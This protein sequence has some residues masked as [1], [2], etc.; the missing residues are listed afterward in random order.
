MRKQTIKLVYFFSQGKN[1]A[2]SF[3]GQ[4]K[5]LWRHFLFKMTSSFLIL[6][7]FSLHFLSR[8]FNNKMLFGRNLKGSIIVSILTASF[9]D[10]HI[11]P[12]NNVVCI[13]LA[14]CVLRSENIVFQLWM[15]KCPF[16][17]RFVMHS[18]SCCSRLKL[19]RQIFNLNLS[20]SY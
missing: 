4:D 7:C 12:G 14:K 13:V 20:V 3:C 17:E 11:I 10:N 18:F 6:C 19:I 15:K 9:I 5:C 16:E 8:N 2:V 1:V